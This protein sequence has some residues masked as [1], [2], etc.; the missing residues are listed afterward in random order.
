MDDMYTTVQTACKMAIKAHNKELRTHVIFKE[1]GLFRIKP[2]EEIVE[3]NQHAIYGW[4]VP[5]WVEGLHPNSS[6]DEVKSMLPMGDDCF[7]RKQFYKGKCF[8]N[9]TEAGLKLYNEYSPDEIKH[10]VLY[11]QEL[12]EEIVEK[13]EK[14]GEYG[15]IEIK[16][17][18]SRF[19]GY[20]QICKSLYR[21]AYHIGWDFNYGCPRD[22]IVF[23]SPQGVISFLIDNG[24][25]LFS[26]K[27]TRDP[28]LTNG[29]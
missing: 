16:N 28:S 11:G 19:K 5:K 4:T 17:A 14:L 23:R 29:L 8:Y 15:I 18:P 25:S 1:V 10:Y 20:I 13:L 24:V 3:I 22:G 7:V 26:L 9:P 27:S 6:M 12:E 21:K 2:I